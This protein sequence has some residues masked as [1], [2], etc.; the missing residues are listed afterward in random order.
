MTDR[1]E[2]TLA[3]LADVSDETLARLHDRLVGA[4]VADALLDVAYRVVD[5]PLGP[6][7]V[8]ATEQ[9]LVRLAFQREDHD[10]VLNTLAERV[11]PRLLH[12][13]RQLDDAARQL[14]D[15]FAGRRHEFV[16]PLDLRLSHGFRR[17]VLRHL[18]TIGYGQRES[19]TA[20]ATVTGHPKA[21]RAVGSA[22]ATNPIP[23]VVPCHR[24]LRSDGSL[25]GYAGGLAAKQALLGLEAAGESYRWAAPE[26][27]FTL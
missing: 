7:L 18:V 21:V 22:C 24:V 25:G 17:Q 6:L 8:A 4:A 13:P 20:V 26:G 10:A 19:Y 2:T 23:I 11:S 9:G 16:L 15:Y 12:A 1:T 3:G 14:A 27:T 5:S